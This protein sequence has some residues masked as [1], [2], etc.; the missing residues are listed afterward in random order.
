MINKI[1]DVIYDKSGNR[2]RV[3]KAKEIFF[4]SKGRKGYVLHIEREERITS[5]SEFELTEVDGRYIL[6]KDVLRNN[7][8][9]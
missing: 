8:D 5:I 7:N 6:T 3:I 4:S 9:I 2:I 1:P